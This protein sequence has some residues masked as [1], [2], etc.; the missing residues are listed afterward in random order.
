MLVKVE[1]EMEN[2]AETFWRAFPDA[3]ADVRDKDPEVYNILRV[4]E[5]DDEAVIVGEALAQ[6]RQRLAV[7][8]DSLRI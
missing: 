7:G 2:D 8:V 5:V 1:L 4:V 6:V 3:I